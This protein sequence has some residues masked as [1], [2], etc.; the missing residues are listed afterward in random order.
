MCASGA[1][2]PGCATRWSQSG[3]AGLERIRA[4]L[5]HHGIAGAPDELRTLAGRQFLAGL[6][7]PI[8]ARERITVAL[9]IIDLLDAQLAKLERDLRARSRAIRPAAGR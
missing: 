5:Y 1:R 2:A 4:T 7:L 9:E 8:D 3:P 6:E